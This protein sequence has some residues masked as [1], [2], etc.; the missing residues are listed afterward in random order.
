MSS[1]YTFKNK[2]TNKL[3]MY[4]LYI[5]IYIYKNSQTGFGIK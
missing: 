2:G 4:E 3:F 5:Y 1:N